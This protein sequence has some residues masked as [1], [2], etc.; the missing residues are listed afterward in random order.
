MLP[1]S[2]RDV[3]LDLESR[4]KSE[5]TQSQLSVDSEKAEFILKVMS[6]LESEVCFTS[7]LESQL[8]LKIDSLLI[9]RDFYNHPATK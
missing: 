2:Y 9:S 3:W 4:D 6:E 7:L 1:P 5:A 8:I